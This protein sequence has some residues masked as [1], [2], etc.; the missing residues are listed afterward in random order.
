MSSPPLQDEERVGPLRDPQSSGQQHLLRLDPHLCPIALTVR[1][2][3]VGTQTG[4]KD[5]VGAPSNSEKH[6]LAA[7]VVFSLMTALSTSGCDALEDARCVMTS[8]I[9]ETNGTKINVFF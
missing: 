8:Q 4:I 2:V 6:R 7:V 5:R 3:H 9:E 1:R